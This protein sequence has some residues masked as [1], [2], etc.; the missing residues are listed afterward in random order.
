MLG[1]KELDALSTGMKTI[2]GIS[3]VSKSPI[4]FRA[5]FESVAVGLTTVVIGLPLAFVFFSPMTQRPNLLKSIVMLFMVGFF[6]HLL[7]EVLGINKWIAK[8]IFS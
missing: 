4:R 6:T 3:T 8:S 5:W 1:L 2:K 7:W